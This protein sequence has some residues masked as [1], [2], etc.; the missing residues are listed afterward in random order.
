M[1]FILGLVVLAWSAAALS[2]Q[3]TYVEGEHYQELVT[4][5]PTSHPEKIEVAEVFAYTCPHCFNFAAPLHEW[6]RQQKDDVVL[7][8]VPAMWNQAMEVYARGF[9]TAKALG[10]LDQ[11]HMPI[12]TALHQEGKQFRSADD[13]AAF[14]A[15][16]GAD[17]KTVEKTYSS[18]GVTSQVKQADAKVRGY[19]ISGTPELVVEGKYRISSRMTG[20]HGEMLKVA[21][22]LIEQIR[23]GEL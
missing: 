19:K 15:D 16:Y 17:P 2:Q 11:V 23:A 13:W 6:E 7:V 4:P 9:Y 14:F 20:S 22:Y 5:V 8:E 3:A 12:F 1:R 10:L 21:D 18:F